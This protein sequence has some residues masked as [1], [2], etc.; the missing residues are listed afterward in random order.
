MNPGIYRRCI[1]I[2]TSEK[3]AR[4]DLEDDLHRYTVIIRHDGTC[5][6]AIEGVPVRVP[7]SLCPQSVK[8]LDLLIGMPLSPHPLAVFRHTD[9][10][11]QCTH[12]FDLAGLAIA[13]AAR[14]IRLRQYDIEAPYLQ[15]QGARSLLLRRDG[16]EVLHW[17]IDGA[18]LLAPE[19]FAGRDIKRL[20]AWAESAYPDPDDYEAIVVLRRAVLISKA[21]LH[22]W[23]IFPTAADTNHGTGACYV[24]QPGVQERA[25]RMKG[26]TREFTD[27]PQ[28]M[29]SD[30][31]P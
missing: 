14:G 25:T 29:L 11:H 17:T 10:A 13:H 30:L 3:E 21:R 19:A 8:A 2:V 6:T 16:V 28:R 9:G 27:A 31:K 20:A 23:D 26:T 22:D 1:R 4:A 12:M 15:E 5:I 18:T 7:W 24:F